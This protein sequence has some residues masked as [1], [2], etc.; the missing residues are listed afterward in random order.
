[1]FR[2][3]P[4]LPLFPVGA[5]LVGGAVRDWLRGV[6][7]KDFDWAVPDPA[8]AARE[9][10]AQVGGSAFPLDEARDYWR[11]HVPEGVQHDFVPQPDDVADD[12]RRRDFTVNALALTAGGKL[13]DPA[14]GQA[15]LRARRL[16]MVS[17]ANLRDDPLRAWRAVRFEVTLGLRMDAATE[18]AVRQVAADLAA[19]RLPMPALERVRDE[20]QALLAHPDA[21]RGVRRLEDLGL[22]ALTLPELREGV[23]V[24]QGGFHHLDVFGHEL[25][26]LH[27][28]LARFP[29]ADLPLRWA[30][31]LHDVGKPR[32]RDTEMRPD[33]TT[34]YGHERVG[35]E[36]ARQ[37]LTRLRLPAA[38]VDR[39]TAL[40]RAHMAHLPISEREARR[41]V[42]R[43]RELLPDLLRLMLADREAARGP[44]ST[45]ATRH[46]Y[47]LGLER[48]LA[49][50]EEQ[51]APP[52]PL[53]TGRDVMALLGVPPGP[54]IGEALRAVAEAQALGEVRDAEEA[55]AFLLGQEGGL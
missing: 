41:F 38:E 45:P 34:F 18:A 13:L 22:L 54:A 51:P 40:V 15:D 2:R 52:P 4:P 6:A 1:M 26:A 27:Q 37:A 42:H 44:Q 36:L 9:L 17:E 14:G 29:D 7:P 48:V 47:A 28:L 46:A 3:R 49:A 24:Q 55:R 33:R 19:V 35:A 12:L 32:T 30:T 53:L 8:Q 23:G 16:R 39:V 10:A 11:V 50:L 5:L 43:R 25:E 21:A 31:L 20:V